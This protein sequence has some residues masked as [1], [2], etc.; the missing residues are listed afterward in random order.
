M[1]GHLVDLPLPDRLTNLLVRPK[2]K[3]PQRS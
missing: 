2:K 1:Y 3:R